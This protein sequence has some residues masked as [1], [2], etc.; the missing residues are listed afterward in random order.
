MIDLRSVEIFFWIATLGSFR[1]A[2]A[3]LNTTQP[4]ISQRMAALEAELGVRLFEREARGVKLTAKGQ[5]LLSHAER[6]LQARHE[7][8]RAAREE[9]V[10]TGRLRIG[11]AETIVQTWLPRLIERIHAAHPA[12]TLEIDVDTTSV[13]RSQL[14]ARKIDVAFLMG[15]LLEPHIDNLPLCR[16]PLA[17]VA[18]PRLDLGHEPL[19][20]EQIASRPVITYPSSSTPYQLVRDM[21]AQASTHPFQLYGSASVALIAQMACDGIGT[22][23]ISP[24][25]LRDELARGELRVLDVDA[26]ALPD[27][28]F[29]AAWLDGPG[30]HVAR[31]IARL[32]QYV[33]TEI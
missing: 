2:A 23:V 19:A 11:T 4:A 20:L 7:M 28:A 14:I 33:A 18:S 24:V 22:A 21:L 8:L 31:T 17:W 5:E 32:A 1:A 6:M 16:Y 30:S 26:A 25:C 15:P 13:L 29:G 10:M 3:K 9:S 12:L 27:L